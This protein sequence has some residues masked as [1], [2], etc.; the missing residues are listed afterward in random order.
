MGSSEYA[1]VVSELAD[2]I[3]DVIDGQVSGEGSDRDKD[4]RY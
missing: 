3:R 4:L 1:K 2:Y